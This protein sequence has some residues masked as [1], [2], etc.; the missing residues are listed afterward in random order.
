MLPILRII[1][2]GGVL[3]AIAILVLALS[4]P[5]GPH[6]HLTSSMTPP[7]GALISRDDHPEWRQFLI[8]AALRRADELS[9]LR[10]LPDTPTRTAPLVPEA[11]MQPE[12]PK[13]AQPM[14]AGNLAGVQ[15]NPPDQGDVTGTVQ[16]PDAVI[17]VDIGESSSTE[18]PVIPHKERPPVVM[19]PAHETPPPVVD[20]TS[21]VLPKPQTTMAAHE[22]VKL[23][24]ASREAMPGPATPKQPAQ[25]KQ[26]SKAAA[27]APSQQESREA[28]PQPT[29]PKQP[30]QPRQKREAA[31]PAPTTS[32]QASRED[33]PQPASP[34]Q[35]VPPKQASKAAAPAT[36]QQANREAALQPP[37]PKQL[38][39]P[40][41]ESKAPAPAVAKTKQASLELPPK[42][43]AKP[44]QEIRHAIRER[45]KP[46]RESRHAVRERARPRRLA[47]RAKGK[48]T[49]QPFNFFQFFFH[50][51]ANQPAARI[52]TTS[53]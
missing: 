23:K 13:A 30:T 42:R 22:P 35:P 51:D 11:V 26:A 20:S 37:T 34:K 45:A 21:P 24:Q 53:Y 29:M 25:R 48:Q 7:R 47:R 16:S 28:T 36:S 17:P 39:Q 50:F 5:A 18:L 32:K 33:P 46:R 9:K 10:D 12:K 4:P 2:V 38:S 8:L 44:E 14:N 19:M 15:A 27:P 43:P 31:A 1:P 41:Q 40:K 49:I 6:L 52:R 3:L